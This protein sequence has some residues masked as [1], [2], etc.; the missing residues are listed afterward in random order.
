MANVEFFFWYGC[1]W[2]YLA[3]GRLQETAMR[4]RAT[5]AWKPILLDRVLAAVGSGGRAAAPAPAKARYQ[6]KDLADWV[7]FCGVTIRMTEPH[8]V[9]A[10][11]AARGGIAVLGMAASSMPAYTEAVFRACFADGADIANLDVVTAIAAGTGL[12]AGAF[13]RAA[14]AQASLAVLER[15]SDEL[16]RRGG[17]ATPTMFV[18]EDMYH[19]ND[20]MPLV[21]FA[22]T[23]AAGR[24]LIVP[25][26]H[27]Q[28]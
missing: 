20:R 18:G 19:G 17:F 11:W 25:G 28:Q 26:A 6:A 24:P 2:T 4:T 21:E 10:E 12:D 7:R 13:R 27:G 14:E 8:H 3:F 9:P 5:I 23:H 1:P 22:L 15:N 16:V